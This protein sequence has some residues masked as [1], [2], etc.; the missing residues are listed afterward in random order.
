M[1]LA[2]S[3]FSSSACSPAFQSTRS[4]SNNAAWCLRADQA[5]IQMSQSR[6]PCL[7]LAGMSS[8]RSGQHADLTGLHIFSKTA[9]MRLCLKTSGHYISGHTGTGF[10]RPDMRH[11]A[12]VRLAPACVEAALREK[13]MQAMRDVVL[14]PQATHRAFAEVAGIKNLQCTRAMSCKS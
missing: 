7:C 14:Q 5:T 8:A 3:S 9:W 11:S 1:W 2:A 4:Q 6:P 13:A 12:A 10:V